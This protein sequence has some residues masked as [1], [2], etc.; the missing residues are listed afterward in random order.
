IEQLISGRVR[1]EA[2]LPGADPVA[3]NLP[4][5]VR[6]FADLYHL[7]E[8]RDEIIALERKGEKSVDNL[9]KQVEESRNNDLYRL[10][11][12][13]GIRHVG[14][15]TAQILADAFDSIDDLMDANESKLAGIFEIGR[16]VAA[17]IAEWFRE[18]RNR[19]LI[20]RLKEAGVNTRR[21]QE[22]RAE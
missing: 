16:V 22:R 3:V 2:S 6:D 1:Q 14:E 7:K 12:G 19:E 4:P 20:A 17:S 11:Y 8:R 5:L 10:V 18:P 9:L 21:K 15:R 13:L